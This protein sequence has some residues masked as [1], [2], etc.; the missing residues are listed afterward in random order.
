MHQH[1]WSDALLAL[2]KARRLFVVGYSLP[3][4]DIYMQSFLKAALGP[5]DQLD[6]I[7]VFDPVL[8]NDDE[9]SRKMRKRYATCFAS[10]LQSRIVFEPPEV[11]GFRRG[12]ID[13]GLYGSTRHFVRL[14]ANQPDQLLF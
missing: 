6:R 2:R 8:G 5:N 11:G 1:V 3:R 12:S 7:V 14:L 10:H 9:A 13:H 4:T